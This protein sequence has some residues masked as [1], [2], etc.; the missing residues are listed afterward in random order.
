MLHCIQWVIV[1]WYSKV[2]N[3][4][5]S[6]LP[7]TEEFIHGTN[8][9]LTSESDAYVKMFVW[10]KGKENE[11]LI[12]TP[13]HLKKMNTVWHWVTLFAKGWKKM[14]IKGY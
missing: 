4:K 10:I 6:I 5:I 8:A 13:P 3:S 9:L 1:A 12:T 2:H 7:F 14:L 11:C